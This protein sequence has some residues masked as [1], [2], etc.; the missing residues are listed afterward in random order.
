[1][2]V[3]REG[4]RRVE[5]ETEIGNANRKLNIKRRMIRIEEGER[6]GRG[7]EDGGWG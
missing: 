1:M 6:R 4:G 5:L 2:G 3:G 7:R